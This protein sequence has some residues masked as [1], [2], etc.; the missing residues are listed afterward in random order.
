MR[1]LCMCLLSLANFVDHIS[2]SANNV[3]S[4]TV[5]ISSLV[6]IEYKSSVG[7]VF[8]IIRALMRLESFIV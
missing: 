3:S 8:V 1:V 2:L 5:Q 4:H 7:F 6:I